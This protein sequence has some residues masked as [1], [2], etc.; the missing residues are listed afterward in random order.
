MPA[1]RVMAGVLALGAL[2]L[3]GC[4]GSSIAPP[5]SVAVSNQPATS[6]TSPSPSSSSRSA[7]SSPSPTPS[8]SWPKGVPAAARRHG[9]PGAVAYARYYLDTV[10]ATG[11]DPRRGVLEPLALHACSQC[12]NFAGSTEYILSRHR[13]LSGDT[14]RVRGAKTV[15]ARADDVTVAISAE[16]PPLRV[17]DAKDRTV[18]RTKPANGTLRLSVRWYASRWWIASVTLAS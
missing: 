9:I 13:H 10:N 5:S 12:A 1:T 18:S 4:T 2:G 17:L 15:R 6:R 7:S 3:A 11:R 16:Q 8:A 14:F